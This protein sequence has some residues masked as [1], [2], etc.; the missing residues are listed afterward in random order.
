MGNLCHVHGE[1]PQFGLESRLIKQDQNSLKVTCSFSCR[2]LMQMIC[3]LVI[4]QFW[5]TII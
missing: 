1:E 2:K 5:P 4:M 3:H